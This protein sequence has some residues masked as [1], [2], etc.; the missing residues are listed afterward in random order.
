MSPTVPPISEITTS[1]RLAA[2]PAAD[3]RLDLVGDVRDHLHRGAEELAA[4]LLAN[5]RQ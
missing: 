3:A 1:A 2:A 5:H 4:P